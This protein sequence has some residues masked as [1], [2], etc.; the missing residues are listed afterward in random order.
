MSKTT[1][2]VVRANDL[3]RASHSLKLSE[4]KLMYL[5]L[6]QVQSDQLEYTVSTA[7]Y[8]TA[9][10]LARQTAHRYCLRPVRACS[11]RHW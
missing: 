7:S 6:L 2:I 4:Q 11:L 3:I 9:Y 10:D 8:A 5:V 1:G